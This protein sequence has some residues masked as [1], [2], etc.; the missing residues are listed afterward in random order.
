MS[1]MFSSSSVLVRTSYSE[2]GG[3]VTGNN[4]LNTLMKIKGTVHDRF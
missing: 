3:G 2:G 4:T 1:F